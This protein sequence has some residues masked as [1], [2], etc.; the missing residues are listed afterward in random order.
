MLDILKRVQRSINLEP[1]VTDI[2]LSQDPVL[3]AF[4]Y[5]V[6][7]PNLLMLPMV[8]EGKEALGSMGNDIPLACMVTRLASSTTTSELFAQ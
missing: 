8:A 1:N 6:E 4:S 7:Q 5:S 3:L 2:M